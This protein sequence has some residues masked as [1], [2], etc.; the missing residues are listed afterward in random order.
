MHPEYEETLFS[1]GKTR[2]LFAARRIFRFAGSMF[3]DEMGLLYS[4]GASEP[5]DRTKARW[6][7]V[8]ARFQ[9]QAIK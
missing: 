9:M 2:D 4:K 3:R 7:T 8:A 1:N 5:E 6:K